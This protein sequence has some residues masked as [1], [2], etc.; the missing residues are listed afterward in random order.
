[1][2]MARQLSVS[3]RLTKKRCLKEM[4]PRLSSAL[5]VQV[6]FVFAMSA[7]KFIFDLILLH[8]NFSLHL[9]FFLSCMECHCAT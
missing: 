1:M 5:E 7:V 8:L 3:Q 4:I 9:R 6:A 2:I